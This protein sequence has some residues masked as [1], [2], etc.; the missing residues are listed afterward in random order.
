MAAPRFVYR[1][2]GL[3]LASD[4]PFP[5]EVEESPEITVDFTFRVTRGPPIVLHG[6]VEERHRLDVAGAPFLRIYETPEIV[7][8]RY[9][10]RLDFE[11]SALTKMVSCR[12]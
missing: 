7:V 6:T 11:W 8:F 4:I 1:V 2:F 3:R 10:G 5:L 12:C 9:P